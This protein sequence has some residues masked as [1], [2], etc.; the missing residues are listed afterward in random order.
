MAG[1]LPSIDRVP[2]AVI[3]SPL[4][5]EVIQAGTSF[6]VQVKISNFACGCASD[7][8]TRWLA[9]P[10]RLS[11]DG[12]VEGHL[13]VVVQ[14]VQDLLDMTKYEFFQSI[15]EKQ[16]LNGILTVDLKNDNVIQGPG[17]YRVCAMLGTCVHATIQLPRSEHFAP[18]GRKDSP[19]ALCRGAKSSSFVPQGEKIYLY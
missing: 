12:L 8:S 3:L 19:V 2:S 1:E 7:G 16:D 11:H 15:D 6:R 14:K 9:E 13:H 18:Q 10:Q 4:D 5:R 17:N